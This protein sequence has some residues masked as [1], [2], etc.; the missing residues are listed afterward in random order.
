MSLNERIAADLK[1][2]MKSRDQARLDV[3]RMLKSAIQ[4]AAIEKGGATAVLNDS[5]VEAVI[6]RQVKQRRDSIAGFEK[7]NRTDLASKEKSELELLQTYLPKE[8][9]SEEP[10]AM[11]DA[12]IKE[13]GATNKAQLGSV[14]K[15]LQPK[16]ARRADGKTVSQ[17]VGKRLA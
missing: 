7:G 3:I 4:M 6:R 12:T 1:E 11:I 13:V 2:A 5:E 9:T 17:E 15:A 16:L 10:G 8:L 14:M